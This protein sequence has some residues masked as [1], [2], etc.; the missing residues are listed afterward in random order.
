MGKTE[1]RL[2][3]GVW[4]YW[5]KNNIGLVMKSSVDAAGGYLIMGALGSL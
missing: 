1:P 3:E 4:G 2:S 5:G